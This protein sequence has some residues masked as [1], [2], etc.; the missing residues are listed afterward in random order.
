M[1]RFPLKRSSARGRRTSLNV[2]VRGGTQLMFSRLGGRLDPLERSLTQAAEKLSLTV[3]EL[4]AGCA[5]GVDSLTLRRAAD[6]MREGRA[7]RRSDIE[8]ISPALWQGIEARLAS[9][10]AAETYGYLRS[11]GDPSRIAVGLKRGLMGDRTG[12]Y[13]VPRAGL[14]GGREEAGQRDRDG[15]RTRSATSPRRTRRT[16][17]CCGPIRGWALKRSSPTPLTRPSRPSTAAFETNSPRAH[18]PR[19]GK[20][21]EP[22]YTR[23]WFAVRRLPGLRWLREHFVG[24][25]IHS[26]PESGARPSTLLAFN[27]R[28]PRTRRDRHRRR[29]QSQKKERVDAG[30][31]ASVPLLQ[32]ARRE[33]CGVLSSMREGTDHSAALPVVQVAHP[34][35]AGGLLKPGMNLQIACPF[36]GQATFFETTA[37]RVARGSRA[38]LPPPAVTADAVAQT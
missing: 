36:C 24:R 19:R 3:Q 5:P 37:T 15:A 21:L 30:L 31:Q 6:I 18:L 22:R 38:A 9:A 4:L 12:E 35:R 8:A 23:Y 29:P 25:A 16:S 27:G 32:H 7:A 20:L 34:S 1:A 14:L 17:A 28:P 11:I 2:I 13:V 10:G 33:G 26:S